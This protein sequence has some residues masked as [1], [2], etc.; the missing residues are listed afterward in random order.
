MQKDREKTNFF[1]HKLKYRFDWKEI[2]FSLLKIFVDHWRSNNDERIE[3]NISQL[4]IVLGGTHASAEFLA[5]LASTCEPPT[6]LPRLIESPSNSNIAVSGFDAPKRT[7]FTFRPEHLDVLF[8][9]T[10]IVWDEKSFCFEYLRF[11]KK[12]FSTILIQT[13]DDVKRSH[14]FVTKLERE[15]M[16]ITKFWMNV[17]VSLTRSSHIG[18]KI[19][20]KWRRVNEVWLNRRWRFFFS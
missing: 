20:E 12:H 5:N 2:L 6:K 14:E 11:L 16:E 15:S 18:F 17:I 7:R 4:F 3:W 8:D 9:W 10:F 1:F 13:H 19:N